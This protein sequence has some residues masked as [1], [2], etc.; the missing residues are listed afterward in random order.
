MRQAGLE[1]PFE[2][3]PEMKKRVE[4]LFERCQPKTQLEKAIVLFRSIIPHH[5]YFKADGNIL[6]GI[7]I[8]AGGLAIPYNKNPKVP[9][10][11]KNGEFLPKE[12]VTAPEE[13]RVAM[14]LEFS[15]LLISFLRAAGIEAYT[16]EEPRHAYV[17]AV[18]DGGKYK[19]DIASFLLEPTINGAI[20]DRESISMHYTTKANFLFEQG[21]T[22]EALEVLNKSLE[23]NP[24]FVGAWNNKGIILRRQGKIEE[25]LE[26]FNKA[27]KI[28]PRSFK[29]WYH[30]GNLLYK[31]GK[32]EEALRAYDVVLWLEPYNN[33][34]VWRKH[35][36]IYSLL[37]TKKR[38]ILSRLVDWVA[39]IFRS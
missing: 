11:E 22:E 34:D 23:I 28:D 10:R 20:T 6:W 25:S 9:I 1:D 13:K 26:A 4:A 32:L 24:S 33:T 12:L 21:K 15:C 5:K 27:L 7:E 38:S 29:V 31:Q 18:L 37:K 3:T 36:R 39:E 17:I 14:C 2:I 16:K 30:K 19:L 8:E 35:L